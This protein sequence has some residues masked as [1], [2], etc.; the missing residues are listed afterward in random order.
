[1][2]SMI[3]VN[4]TMIYADCNP[5]M[6]GNN[7]FYY[8]LA[9]EFQH[10]IH[11]NE[12][13]DEELW[14]NEGCSEYAGFICGY[15]VRP[16]ERFFADPNNSLTEWNGDLSDYEK[17]FL[18][19]LYMSEKYGGAST[20]TQLVK[21][22]GNGIQGIENILQVPFHTIFS[23]WIVANY[24][25]DV[26]VENGQYGY[27]NI[28]LSSYAMTCDQIH[29][30]YPVSS[31]GSVNRWASEY[32]KFTDG[33]DVTF[34]YNGPASAR[35]IETGGVNNNVESISAEKRVPY[36]GI[37]YDQVILVA[38]GNQNGGYYDYT[39]VSQNIVRPDL[40]VYMG[41]DA[42]HDFHYQPTDHICTFEVSI[43]NMG[44]GPAVGFN[45]GYYL[46]QDMIIN[47][48]DYQVGTS[49]VSRLDIGEHV[50]LSYS[51]DL[52]EFASDRLP[53]GMY[54][55]GYYV[56]YQNVVDETNEDDNTGYWDNPIVN[57]VSENNDVVTVWIESNLT[58][59][60][61]DGGSFEASIKVDDVTGMGIYAYS[62]EVIYSSTDLVVTST[63]SS[64]CISS[65]WG[66]PTT[67]SHPGKVNIASAGTS[68]LTGGGDLVKINFQ[69]VKAHTHGET[70]PLQ[71][72]NVTLN[73]GT[74]GVITS[75]G[76]VTFVENAAISGTVKY[77]Q[78]DRPISN[79]IMNLSGGAT[80]NNV[81]NSYGDYQFTDLSIGQNYQVSASKTESQ[82]GAISAFDASYILR[83][84]VGS[85][86][87]SNEQNL[88]A[89][90][91]GDGSVS[92]F[93]A[94]I[95]LRY[96]VGID[97][98]SYDIGEWLFYVPLLTSWTSPKL[99]RN[100]TPL[101]GDQTDQDFV[102]V[103][104]GDVSG[105]WSAPVIARSTGGSV[106]L[107]DAHVNAEG[108]IEL[109]I[110]IEGISSC[111]SVT[112]ELEIEADRGIVKNV[113]MFEESNKAILMY[114]EDAGKLRIALAS[115]ERIEKG[116]LLR[117]LFNVES[118]INDI[119]V[120]IALTGYEIDGKRVG[121]FRQEVFC[122]VGEMPLT[123][124]LKQN[125]PNPF[126]SQTIIPYEIPYREH[127]LL[128]VI[129]LSGRVVA[130]LVNEEQNPGSYRVT[131]NGRDRVGKLV[132][133]GV[134]I[135]EFKA[136]TH[137]DVR[138]VLHLR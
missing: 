57:W 88:A 42:I 77:F 79:V 112:V 64:G 131:W 113:A 132:S 138:R 12:D 28:D 58:C 20:I 36:F 100:Y 44:T 15:G 66:D 16:P 27:Q 97:V 117:V 34:T 74:P 54:Y 30:S 127:V 35:L 130:N 37:L 50:N 103:L 111:Y 19:I 126:N 101:N 116:D 4:V 114:R 56:D 83:G 32:I 6:P 68:A 106:V 69:S 78:G 14:I 3:V 110:G 62:L 133:S 99:S 43:R 87:F 105:N 82:P 118:E 13:R 89:D 128:R 71:L 73:E 137:R 65:G 125:Y 119:H 2:K 81:T 59:E 104:I 51:K 102:G 7:S 11:W 18:W 22:G 109:P 23:N 49:Y 45:V 124:D 25:D 134:Y 26:S 136:G 90:V 115:S 96:T 108:C 63:T 61:N 67:G 40:T 72:K 86:S 95:V 17:C 121:G 52:D 53:T 24:L 75:D 33:H 55:A 10:M 107:G 5:A 120:P 80:Q 29:D 85:L 41:V 94:S 46:S 93:D 70:S 48:N 129:D 91:S 39:A 38:N 9:H 8:M 122:R 1:M 92:A 60:C 98:S 76:F 135:Y 47:E 21:E 84:A 123:F 31:S